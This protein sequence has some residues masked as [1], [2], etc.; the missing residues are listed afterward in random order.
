MTK[1]NTETQHWPKPDWGDSLDLAGLSAPERI[2]NVP[3]HLRL[4]SGSLKGHNGFFFGRDRELD[5]LNGFFN[6][7]LQVCNTKTVL[8]TSKVTVADTSKGWQCT[9]VVTNAPGAGKSALLEEFAQR[10]HEQGVACIPVGPELMADKDHLIETLHNYAR[11]TPQGRAAERREVALELAG[12]PSLA[13]IIGGIGGI[14]ATP[15]AGAAT[16]TGIVALQ[17]GIERL[18]GRWE[19]SP[20][21]TVATA[22]RQL[23]ECTP[24]GFVIMV[25]ECTAW[26]EK[27]LDR[28]TLLQHLRLIVEPSANPQQR[29]YGGLLMAGLG[30][31]PDIADELRLSRAQTHWLGSL[32]PMDARRLLATH[33][34]CAELSDERKVRLIVDWV[35]QLA[36][37]FHSWPEHTAAAASI[38]LR[39]AERTEPKPGGRIPSPAEDQEALEW[40]RTM[41][42]KSVRALYRARC[43]SAQ[44]AGGPIVHHRLVA[45]ANLTDNRMPTASTK[46]VIT[47]CEVEQA[48]AERRPTDVPGVRRKL[49]EAGLLREL[50]QSDEE[51][52]PDEAE[53]SE[54]FCE[55]PIPNLRRHVTTNVHPDAMARAYEIAAAALRKYNPE[56]QLALTAPSPAET[57]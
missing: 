31:A 4:R 12:I 50:E 32:D 25:D 55:I 49:K 17:E 43:R 5:Q 10:Q 3:K 16:G 41:T 51:V 14:A 26:E 45:L 52:D 34:T 44:D 20:P 24:K 7:H 19:T 38:G 13:G 35:P 9:A 47:G 48:E 23:S 22:L 33:F 28:T 1:A 42:A 57:S 2:R 21:E 15:V 27:A 46:A 53:Q 36:K 37:D 39:I 56:C 6:Q 40:V 11:E 30:A 54:E 29:I 18:R 8:R